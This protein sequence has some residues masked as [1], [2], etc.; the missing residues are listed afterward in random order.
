MLDEAESLPDDV[1]E[2]PEFIQGRF[3]RRDCT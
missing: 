1:T 2:E 3:V